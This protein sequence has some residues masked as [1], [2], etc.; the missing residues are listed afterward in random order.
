MKI[1]KHKL[2]VVL[3][4]SMFLIATHSLAADLIQFQAGQPAKAAEVNANF[5]ALNQELTAL[6]NF[7]QLSTEQ[8]AKLRAAVGVTG[9]LLEVN[10]DCTSN[11]EAL[12][13]EWLTIGERTNWVSFKIK[14]SCYANLVRQYHNFTLMINGTEENRA[15]KLIANAEGEISLLGSFNGGLYLDNLT[16]DAPATSTPVLFSRSAEGNINAVTINGAST[17]V[18]IQ[19]NAQ[20][21]I[22]NINIFN[23]SNHGIRV[24][25]G[26]SL[27]IFGN[28]DGTPLVQTQSGTG[29]T[30]DQAHVSSIVAVKFNAPTALNISGNSATFF[31]SLEAN[32]DVTLSTASQ[33]FAQNF[34]AIGNINLY[35][36]S[37][38]QTN[39][40]DIIG[41][42][43]V[44]QGSSAVFSR[45]SVQASEPNSD[46]YNEALVLDLNNNSSG[47]IGTFS[48]SNQITVMGHVNLSQGYLRA[49]RA[50]L[51]ISLFSEAGS[52]DARNSSLSSSDEYPVN[53]TSNSSVILRNSMSSFK[54]YS[55]QSNSSFYCNDSSL[56]QTNI[57]S[58]ASTFK[59][60]TCTAA[61]NIN[62]S[63]GSSAELRGADFRDMSANLDGNSSINA[64]DS[65]LA[66][67]HVRSNSDVTMNQSEITG[68]VTMGW[69]DDNIFIDS[70]SSVAINDSSIQGIPMLNNNGILRFQNNVSTSNLIVNCSNR[71][72]VDYWTT[73]EQKSALIAGFSQYGCSNNEQ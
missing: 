47:F 45:G 56:S 63:T 43:R 34:K 48:E 49:E 23:S 59:T 37:A 1:Y 55:L 38:L 9:D 32:G 7:E 8:V 57:N 58:S 25:T 11:P 62:L 53:I 14:G 68:N 28:E 3:A 72:G 46:D 39:F 4:L 44:S 15:S 17:A 41:L 26:G 33:L 12:Q 65:K 66:I 70:S 35:M 61:G 36:S 51:N 5:Q 60:D 71:S 2:S 64:Y 6:G 52:I 20:A 31:Q 18:S 19:A 54:N 22:S 42:V 21:Y 16:I 50:N 40:T 30:V 27:R 69:G 13:Q 67:F 73:P 24:S 10:V 29:L